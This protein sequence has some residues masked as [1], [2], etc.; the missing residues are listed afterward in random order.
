MCYLSLPW[1]T[2]VIDPD[3]VHADQKCWFILYVV[4]KIRNNRHVAS[5]VP[6]IYLPHKNKL[7]QN[8]PECNLTWNF[9]FYQSQVGYEILVK[10]NVRVWSLCCC[11]TFFSLSFCKSQP[12]RGRELNSM[13]KLIYTSPLCGPVLW[14]LIVNSQ[15]LAR[16]P[17]VSLDIS[18]VLS[19]YDLTMPLLLLQRG[20]E[21]LVGIVNP[22]QT[23]PWWCLIPR[24]GTLP[25]IPSVVSQWQPHGGGGL[26]SLS[27]LPNTLESIPLLS[28]WWFKSLKNKLEL[29]ILSPFSPRRV[30]SLIPFRVKGT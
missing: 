21:H 8:D 20:S 6:I 29:E 3:K 2:K 17:R 1:E 9:I 27:F 10:E 15:R 16:D 25:F 23:S 24:R 12:A 30:V 11:Y 22:I 26:Q 7:P 4:L 14:G 5:H 18:S 19:V 28:V 13:R